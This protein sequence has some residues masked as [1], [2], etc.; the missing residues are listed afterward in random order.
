LTGL[1]LLGDGKNSANFHNL[2]FLCK[3]SIQPQKLVFPTRAFALVCLKIFL[4]KKEEEATNRILSHI[5][6]L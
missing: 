4:K 5:K 2:H 1:N 3:F 6:V